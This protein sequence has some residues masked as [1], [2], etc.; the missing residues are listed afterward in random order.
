MITDIPT[1]QT[2]AFTDVFLAVLA[3]VAIAALRP[4]AGRDRWK[5]AVWSWV[6]GLLALSATLG[7]AAHGLDIP[8]GVRTALWQ[9]L[10]L[11]LGALVGLFVVAAVYELRG[12][13]A[14]RRLLPFMLGMAVV[15]YGLTRLFSG[16]F[17]VFLIYEAAAMVLAL[18][19]F[20]SLARAGRRGAGIIAVAIVINIVAAAIQESESV[21]VT[22]IWSFDHNGLFHL[23]QMVAVVVLVIGLRRSLAET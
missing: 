6:F 3:M 2:T 12:R 21:A 19:I 14:A 9:P 10:F 5:V 18:L 11:A 8:P 22:W 20:L 17:R 7:A 13:G 16:M 4:H 15:F 1:E 23:V